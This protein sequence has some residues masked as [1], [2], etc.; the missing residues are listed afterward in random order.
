MSRSP[1]LTT[2]I[3]LVCVFCIQFVI[4]L[5]G[6]GW[7]FILSQPVSFA[8]WR[9]VTSVY[10]HASIGHLVAN[11]VALVI[12]GLA[13]ER[14]TTSL[15]FHLFFLISGA[16]AGLTQV[17]LSPVSVLGASG[18]VFALLG[19][20][21]TSNT[22]TNGLLGRMSGRAQVIIFV[23]IAAVVTVATAGPNVALIAHFAGLVIGL[24]AGRL[25][26]LHVSGDGPTD[27]RAV[28][29]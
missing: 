2:A 10:A 7:W 12:F 20:A 4:G 3:V 18:A 21:L 27:H 1:T 29:L 14:T 11:L 8:P 17:S 26:L 13:V 22:V 16:L 9:L 24:I 25:R 15:R 19:Y 6:L 5:I 23:I 28:E